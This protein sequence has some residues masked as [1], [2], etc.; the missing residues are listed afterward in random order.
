MEGFNSKLLWR[1]IGCEEIFT[2]IWSM[3]ILKRWENLLF[4]Y[5]L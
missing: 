4:F 5:L 1:E 3:E 2:E